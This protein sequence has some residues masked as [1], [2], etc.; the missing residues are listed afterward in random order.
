MKMTISPRY[1]FKTFK[2]SI[3]WIISVL[4][5]GSFAYDCLFRAGAINTGN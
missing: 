4:L 5:D 1:F 3:L 2:K